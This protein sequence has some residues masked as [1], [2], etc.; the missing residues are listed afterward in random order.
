VIWLAW[1]QQRTETVI[2]ALLL[3]LAAVVLVPTGL[4]MASVYDHDGIAACLA[5]PTDSCDQTLG[6]F[7][8]RWDSLANLVAWFNLLPGLVG[9][10]FA[11]P[12]VLELEHGTH[13]LAWTQ[14]VTRDRW[15]AI[16][17]ALIACATVLA[18]LVFTF[19]M[20]WWRA[21]LDRVGGRMQDGFD[22]EGIVPIAYGLFAAAVVLAVGVVL[23]RTAAAVGLALVVYVALRIGIEGWARPHYRAPIHETTT[24]SRLPD[25]HGAWVI[26]ET[27][28]LRLP[29]GSTIDPAVA[30]S[31]ANGKVIDRACLASHGIVE[32][33]TAVYHPA[34]RFWLFQGMETA[35]F[36]GLALALGAFAVVW[37]RRRVS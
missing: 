5:H 29:H 22:F 2:A 15:L 31:C 37:I 14:S 23:R 26:T 1:R 24:G 16:R 27:R 17:V 19:A 4:H 30:S 6:L 9:V 8:S 34:S 20:T 7:T 11:A 35:I 36:L 32:Y 10:L 33:A 25:L 18:M 13:R 21:P 3:L 28:G 12:L